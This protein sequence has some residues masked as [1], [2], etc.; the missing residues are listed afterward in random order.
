MS[1]ARIS[2]EASDVLSDRDPEVFKASLDG[3]VTLGGPSS[4]LAVQ[5]Y[6]DRLATSA[7]HDTVR[8]EWIDEALE[9]LR[10]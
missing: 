3:L 10:G 1:L 4:V 8:V 6:R 2:H 7:V 5:A 9:Q